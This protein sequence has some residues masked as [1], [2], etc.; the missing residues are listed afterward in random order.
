MKKLNVITLFS[1][2]DSQCLALERLG[3]PYELVGWCEVDRHAIKAHDTLFPQWADRN[4]GDVSGVIWSNI[5]QKIDL[6]TYSSP[7][8]DF[9]QAGKQQGGAKG[10]GTRSGLLWECERAIG[11]LKPKYLLFENVPALVSDK[12]FDTFQAWGKVL[13]LFGY[14]NYW[15]CLNAKHYGVPQ[16]RNRVFMVSVYG[17]GEPYYFPK[18]VKLERRLKD[19]LEKDVDESYYL[20][21][22]RIRNLLA[23][24]DKENGRGNGFGFMPKDP[25][26][27]DT[28]SAVL[29]TTGSR[30]TDNF[31]AEPAMLSQVRTEEM[32]EERHRHGGDHGLKWGRKELRPREEGLCNTLTSNLAKDNLL[33]ERSIMALPHGYYQG[34]EF[35]MEAPSVKAS[36]YTET[37]MVVER[38]VLG[39]SRDEHGNVTDRHP[40]DVANCVTSEKGSNMQNYVKEQILLNGDSEGN[41]STITTGHDCASHITE[42]VGGHRQMGVLEYIVEDSQGNRRI[43]C[44][45]IRRLT[46]R[47]LFR[48][49]DVDDSKIDKLLSVGIPKT[50]LAKMAGNS[51][52]VNVLYHIF[53]RLF[54][55]TEPPVNEQLKLF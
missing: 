17:E 53:K 51:I 29:T 25:D 54:V 48:L 8:Q 12:F 49:M 21:E 37:N 27:C 41:A 14:R 5:K 42:P 7:C 32:R 31:I 28:S 38:S 6:L 4:L 35:D 50:Q 33:M 55:D 52:V 26:E 18:K 47:E 40:V 45:R 34:G 11:V 1:G 46:P 22:E 13:Q 16:N 39:W 30:K 15:R 10:S 43:K 44:V 19:L 23:S 3:I 2:Y 36:A 20:S 24:T 9:S